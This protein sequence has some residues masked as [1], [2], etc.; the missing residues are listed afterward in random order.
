[1]NKLLY[2]L[3][4]V[5]SLG[6]SQGKENNTLKEDVS[7]SIHK[8]TLEYS[9]AFLTYDSLLSKYSAGE[10]QVGSVELN[11]QMVIV[12]ASV[13]TYFVY[14]LLGNDSSMRVK[15]SIVNEKE[16]VLSFERLLWPEQAIQTTD[17]LRALLNY[18]SFWKLSNDKMDCE[19]ADGTTY[20][21][22][23]KQGKN[24]NQILRWSPVACDLPKGE[25]ILKIVDYL[26]SLVKMESYET[27]FFY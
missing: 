5:T 18:S 19:G 11:A 27:E 7:P 21:V 2:F 1:M 17:S 14:S 13:G 12:H 26:L 10:L 4:A 24:E 25:E 16:I 6:C 15:F 8:E 23:I 9:D 22:K 20:L 3:L